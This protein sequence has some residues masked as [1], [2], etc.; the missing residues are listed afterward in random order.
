MDWTSDPR[1]PPPS[2]A[3]Q[4][5]DDH[6]NDHGDEDDEN[7]DD[8]GVYSSDDVWDF[9]KAGNHLLFM[10]SKMRTVMRTMMIK[11]SYHFSE[12]I[13]DFSCFLF[14]RILRMV[15]LISLEIFITV[16]STV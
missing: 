16:D 6:E 9:R 14:I 15:T 3:Y 8:H 13:K 7:D 4:V 12:D 1:P 11:G 5:D 10:L 2:H